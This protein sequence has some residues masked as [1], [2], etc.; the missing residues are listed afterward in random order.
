MQFIIC[1]RYERME[2]QAQANDVNQGFG[3]R[4]FGMFIHWGLYAIPAWHEQ[5]Q[6]R[7]GM[8]K[9]QYQALQAQ[10]DPQRFDPDEWIDLAEQAGMTYI[11]FT[12]KHHD[13]FCL[14]D[15]QYT[16]FKITQTPYGRDT[17]A[18][19][20]EACE[21][22]GMGLSLYYSNPDWHHPNGYNP[23]STHQVP[24]VPEDEPDMDRYIAFV[25]NQIA[26]LCTNYGKIFSFFW[27]IPPRIYDPS[28]NAI[29]RRLQPG[30]LINDRGFDEGD[31]STPERHV[32]EG[33]KFDKPT[34]AVQSIGRQSWGYRMN[35]DYYSQQFLTQSIAK[36]MAMGGNYVLNVGPKA[37]GTIPDIGARMI[38]E[39]GLWYQSVKE[40]YEDA[41]PISAV[42]GRKDLM[43]TRNGNALY[44][45]LVPTPESSGIILNPVSVMPQSTLLLNNGTEV[46]A[47]VE[48]MPTLANEK[49]Y[50]HLSDIPV[51]EFVSQ[52]MV[53]KLV[54]DDL[55]GIMDSMG[56]RGQVEDRL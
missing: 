25:K 15:T 16:D 49:D 47:V 40:A 52:V 19:L 22:R 48:K 11:C 3:E 46:K 55:D 29:I 4:R 43:F 1:R 5:I 53:I 8:D 9:P 23:L 37:D 10:F 27:D 12:V 24:P 41:E 2:R 31:Y 50:L 18:M 30:I 13:G 35:E 39:V 6:M 32:P 38:R 14:W 7:Q 28:L 26:E 45:H 36:I 21:R 17:L 51:N 42:F 34:E 56:S 44:V 20:A 54:F 33:W